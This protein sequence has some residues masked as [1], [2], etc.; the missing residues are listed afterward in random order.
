[1]NMSDAENISDCTEWIFPDFGDVPKATVKKSTN[2]GL[3]TADDVE[4]IYQEARKEGFENGYSAGIDSARHEIDTTINKMNGFMQILEEPYKH[5]SDD[6]VDSI[7]KIAILIAAQIVRREISTDEKNI[8]AAIN[9]SLSLVDEIKKPLTIHVNPSDIST[10]TEYLEHMEGN[11]K[12]IED[13]TITRGGCRIV[14]SQSIIDATIE[15]QITEIAA[16]LIG[17]SRIEDD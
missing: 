4:Q 15:S 7:K 6:V 16:T 8:I 17:G 13:V 1:M 9:K 10:V 3:P 14:T 5:I 2:Q 11:A 12:F